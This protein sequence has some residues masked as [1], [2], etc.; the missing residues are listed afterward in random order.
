MGKVDK[1]IINSSIFALFTEDFVFHF[2][3][4]LKLFYL[5]V[6][7][8][9][10]LLIYK[11][12]FVINK[13]HLLIVLFFIVHGVIMSI[14]VS[15]VVLS[16]FAQITGICISSFFFYNLLKTYGK[17]CLFEAYLKFAFVIALLAIPMF[18]LRINVFVGGDRLNGILNEP[19]HYAAIMLPAVFVLLKRKSYFKFGLIVTTI[20]LSKSSMGYLGLLLIV[21]IP[22]IKAKYLLKYLGVFLVISLSSIY[23][24]SSNWD[25]PTNREDSNV[26]VRRIKETT[27][28][29][30]EGLK[31]K[32]KNGVNLSTY[33]L[34]SNSFISI[35]SIKDY[36][37][38]TGLG[39]YPNQYEKYYPLMTPPKYLLTLDQSKINK[40]DANSL[41]LRF[42]VDLGVFSLFFIVYFVSRSIKLFK[43]DNSDIQQA[44]FFYLIVKL[45]REGHYFP[46]EFYFF[47]LIFVK[48]FD[49]DIT[50]SRELV[51]S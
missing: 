5:I 34:L 42:F 16:L 41:F 17:E 50:H 37:L 32:F 46:P 39:S 45:I 31:G 6:I 12:S 43:T 24:L 19:A 23:Y 14:F 29:F 11:K 26:F 33:A 8:N 28:S 38:G 15:N 10:L 20:L 7:I 4:D 13:N 47:L 22:M 21:F 9:S 49:K 40:F 18:Y 36:P 35:K 27:E 3:I 2:I 51:N 48:N 30:E 25:K 1:Y 44:T